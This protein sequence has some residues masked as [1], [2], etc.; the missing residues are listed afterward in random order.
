LNGILSYF[1]VEAVPFLIDPTWSRFWV[2]FISIWAYMGFYTLILLAGLQSIPSVLYEAGVID[3]TTPWQQFRFITLPLLMPTM[4]VV[5]VLS[6]IRAVQIF[7]AVF[8][9]TGGGPGT[10]NL[11]MVQYIYNTGFSNQVQIFGLSAAA[12]VVMGVV[13]LIF[14]L[15]QLRLGQAGGNA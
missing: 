6:L 4:F 13:L 2:I 11:F 15:I 1:E 10:A 9:L 7:D 3:G 14:T 12:S 8:V 5:L